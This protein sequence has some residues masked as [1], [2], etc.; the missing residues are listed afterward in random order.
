[1]DEC[2]KKTTGSLTYQREYRFDGLRLGLL[3]GP[4]AAGVRQ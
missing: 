3:R 1:M 2:G 4:G